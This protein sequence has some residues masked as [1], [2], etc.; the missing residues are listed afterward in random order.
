ME[1]ALTVAETVADPGLLARVHRGL[2]ILHHWLG[3]HEE[4]REHGREAIALSE[5]AGDRQSTFW[6]YWQLAVQ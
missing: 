2:M 1:T 5:Q 4:V 6:V 3:D